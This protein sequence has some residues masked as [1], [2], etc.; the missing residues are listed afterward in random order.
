VRNQGRSIAYVIEKEIGYAGRQ[1]FLLFCLGTLML[2]VTVFTLMVADGFIATPAVATSSLLF[3]AMAPFFGILLNRR[4]LNLV[5]GTLIFVPLL[6]FFIW[7]GTVCPFD[8]ASL[9]GGA[10]TA[11]VAWI[12]VLL[13][14]AFIASVIP[15]WILL[16]PRDYLNSYLLYAMMGLAVG[17]IL[18]YQPTLVMPAVEVAEGSKAIPGIFPL[19]FVT[20]ACGACSGFH[21]LVASGTSSKQ[22]DKEQN[23]LTVGYGGMLLE[24]VLAI[25]S[26][27]SVAY[28]GM[29]EFR[30]MLTGA[31]K[32]PPQ[33]AF[34]KGLSNF[35][36]ALGLKQE[37]AYNFCSL[38]ISAFILTSLDTAT[39][40]ARFVLQEM[41]L[42]KAG[43]E[44]TSAATPA[45]NTQ[46]RMNWRI[47]LG[48]RWCATLTIVV[49]AAAL[50]FS[51]EVMTI[52]PV[53]GASNQ[54]L[55]ALTLLCVTLWLVRNKRPMLFAL[56]PMIFMM[57]IS[58][59][60]LVCLLNEKLHAQNW[61]LVIACVILLVLAAA[62]VILAGKRLFGH[63]SKSVSGD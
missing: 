44:Q 55:A 1:I 17:G 51:G 18:A 15:V 22:V 3:I 56:L 58:V 52:W 14:Y 8:L 11:R 6:F 7:L 5:Q 12:I 29:P 34:A 2:V 61:P 32:I 36:T 31:D 28:M 57:L 19:L 54:L 37:L 30:E 25:I 39:R 4:L 47:V 42:P 9:V 23:I 41:V 63:S 13:C 49:L 24:G 59:W 35:A 33:L 62:L 50:G 48:N 40:L 27:I 45:D 20:I 43:Q 53:F 60:A 26:I 16:Q 46:K 38:A 21:A 10:K